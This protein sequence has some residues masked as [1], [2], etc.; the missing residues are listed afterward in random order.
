MAAPVAHLRLALC[1]LPPVVLEASLL[2][3]G[4]ADLAATAVLAAA[5]VLMAQILPVQAVL[6]EEK[7]APAADQMQERPEL[8]K[9]QQHMTLEVQAGHAEP[10]AAVAAVVLLAL[11]AVLE[12][13]AKAAMER[14][15]ERQEQPTMAAAVV[16]A[17]ITERTVIKAAL[18]ALAS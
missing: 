4:L 3:V 5:A 15:Q 13:A 7:V 18:A 10:V 2:F 6:M 12:A 8:D 11:Q 17:A 1:V 16:A 9:G 14:Q